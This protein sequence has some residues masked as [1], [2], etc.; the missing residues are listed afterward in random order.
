MTVHGN[1]CGRG[2]GYRL[3]V[4]KKDENTL[5][6]ASQLDGLW[7]TTDR[8]DTWE[9]LPLEENYMTCVWVSDDSKTIVAGT[10]G[11]TTRR[12]IR[13]AV[14]ACMFPM[15]QGRRLKN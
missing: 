4:D 9:R 3:V 5:Y 13:F 11:Y 14:T 12:V 1:L 6:F 7:K 2:T 15:M 10:A 8:G